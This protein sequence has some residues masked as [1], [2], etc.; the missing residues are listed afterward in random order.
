M[1][2]R[3]DLSFE[4]AVRWLEGWVG[5]RVVFAC[6]YGETPNIFAQGELQRRAI[7][8]LVHSQ[9]ES[10]QTFFTVAATDREAGML[11]GLSRSEFEA[12]SIVDVGNGDEL[13]IKEGPLFY[14]VH[15]EESG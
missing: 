8:T 6:G 14:A 7:E 9:T 15:L 11:F 4:V 12:A 2:D 5:R 3:R 13:L 10:D 1:S